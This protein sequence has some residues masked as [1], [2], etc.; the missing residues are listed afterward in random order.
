EPVYFGGTVDRSVSS[1]DIVRG[2][3]KRG[4]NARAFETRDECGDFI[5]REAQ[6]GDRVVIM[7]ARDDTLTVFAQEILDRLAT[8]RG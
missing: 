7:G 5:L 2:V 8:R 1:G 4:G 6:E 3:S